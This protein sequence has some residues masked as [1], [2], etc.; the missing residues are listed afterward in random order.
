MST[1]IA[2][3]WFP[4]LLL[5]A[6]CGGSMA[7]ASTDGAEVFSTICASCHGPDGKPPE[8]QIARLGVR[9]LTAAEFRARVTAELVENQVRHGSTNKL[10]PPFEGAL[11]DAQIKAVSSYVA[12]RFKK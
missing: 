10:M 1:A 11:T 6:S 12:T 4:L 9:D 3:R 5:T 2:T 8:A 7:T